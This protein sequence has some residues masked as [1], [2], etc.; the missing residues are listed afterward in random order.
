MSQWFLENFQKLLQQVPPVPVETPVLVTPPVVVDSPALAPAPVQLERSQRTRAPP[1][2]LRDFLCDAVE[3][4]PSAIIRE[5][6]GEGQL[7]VARPTYKETQ[8]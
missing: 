3:K 8:L 4:H 5:I 1:S 7:S 6:W 2:Y